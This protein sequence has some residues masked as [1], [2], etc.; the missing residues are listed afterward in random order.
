MKSSF[1]C[2][3]ENRCAFCGMN[4][5]LNA[6]RATWNACDAFRG[7]EICVCLLNEI[8]IEICF[9]IFFWNLFL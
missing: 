6:S 7:N 2:G 8:W 3:D 5:I 1:F 4:V 9:C